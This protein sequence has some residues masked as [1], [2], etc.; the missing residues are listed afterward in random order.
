[1][2][3]TEVALSSPR[4]PYLPSNT[5]PDSTRLHP[6][7]KYGTVERLE[8]VIK[9]A[10]RVLE[11]WDT[12]DK[13]EGTKPKPTENTEAKT[14]KVR[15]SKLDYV[16]VDEV[17]IPCSVATILLMVCFIAG[18]VVHPDI[19]SWSQQLSRKR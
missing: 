7:Q 10:D 17:Y 15:A 13:P 3:P 1:M 4:L 11:K 9:K 14:P 16:L 12:K 19:K 8:Q 6:L 5:P 18:I 2:K